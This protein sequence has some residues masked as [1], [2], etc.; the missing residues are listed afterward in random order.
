MAHVGDAAL[1][2][3]GDAIHDHRHAAR[4]VAFVTHF[5]V[6][7][8]FE[9]AGRLLDRAL[10][11]VLGHV[12]VERLVYRGAQARVAG[13]IAATGARGHADLAR[14]LGE[15]ATAARVLRVLAA[16][17]GWTSTHGYLFRKAKRRIL[18]GIYAIVPDRGPELRFRIL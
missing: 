7:D 4:R 9:F 15:H 2:V 6:S 11:G 17:D 18:T 5:L 13:R 8:A 3:V 12:G 1:A 16:F 14:Q 10:D